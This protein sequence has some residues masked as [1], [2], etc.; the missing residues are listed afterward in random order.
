MSRTILLCTD[1]SDLAIG[2][3]RQSLPLLAPGDRTV[4][5]TVESPVD[6]DHV[7]GNGFSTAPGRPPVE[8]QIQTD[9]D[10]FAKQH[11][12]DTIEALGITDV[13]LLAV[14][15][16]PGEQICRVAA[17]LPASVVVIG[18]HGRTGLRRA[19]LGSTSDHVVRHSPC[20]VLVQGGAAHA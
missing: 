17:D 8:E 19:M 14:V 9:G 7:T 3:L 10:R 12:D 11:L 13:E 15:G 5:M 1:G 16:K 4:V 18:T 2:A 20:P 6:A